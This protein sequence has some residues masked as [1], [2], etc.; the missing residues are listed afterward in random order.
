[1]ALAPSKHANGVEAS[2]QGAFSALADSAVRLIP[3]NVLS[4]RLKS[5]ELS[6]ASSENERLKRY[7][8]M[9]SAQSASPVLQM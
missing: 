6:V 2:S 3:V 7:W 8:C 5:L 4:S 9:M 1:M